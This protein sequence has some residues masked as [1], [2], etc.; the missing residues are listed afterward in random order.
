MQTLVGADAEVPPT[1][2]GSSFVQGIGEFA[3]LLGG[4]VLLLTAALVVMPGTHRGMG[5]AILTGSL[6]SL[7]LGGGF[8]VGTFL[9]WV[10]GVAGI[11]AD[12]EPVPYG[13]LDTDW[14]RSSRTPSRR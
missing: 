9:G 8:L 3:I 1:G 7:P 6:L 14:T 5:I 2:G 4:V 11:A 13:E 12:P 10:R